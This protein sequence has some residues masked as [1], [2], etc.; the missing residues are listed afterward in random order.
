MANQLVFTLLFRC[1]DVLCGE[2]MV[3]LLC[4][5]S[6]WDT[7]NDGINRFWRENIEWGR[8]TMPIWEY[9]CTH[10][11][12]GIQRYRIGRY[13]YLVVIMRPFIQCVLIFPFSSRCSFP[14][15]TSTI[16]VCLMQPELQTKQSFRL[17]VDVYMCCNH[18]MFG[19]Y[20]NNTYMTGTCDFLCV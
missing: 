4:Y 6:I 10:G 5:Q 9:E 7:I 11:V 2:P 18:I 20:Y 1:S 14:Q 17:I 13:A 15:I 3:G 16:F 8:I 19:W 12:K